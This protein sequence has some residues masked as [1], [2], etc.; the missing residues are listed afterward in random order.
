LRKVFIDDG[1]DWRL[2]RSLAP[3]EVKTARQMGWSELKNGTLLREAAVQFDVFLS[4]DS[5]I[6]HQNNIATIDIAVVILEPKRNK[7]SEL[8]PLVPQLLKIL[9]TLLPGTVT[10]VSPEN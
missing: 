5:G 9:P 1:V 8:L 7:L 4:T 2:L 10:C 6:E 3:H